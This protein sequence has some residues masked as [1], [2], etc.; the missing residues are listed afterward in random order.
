[1]EAASSAVMGVEGS[2]R[3]CMR[4]FLGALPWVLLGASKVRFPEEVGILGDD[5]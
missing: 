5:R 1:M 3:G 4:G 2:G